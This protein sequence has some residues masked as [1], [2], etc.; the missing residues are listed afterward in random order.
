MAT[1]IRAVTSN[2]GGLYGRTAYFRNRPTRLNWV[3]DKSEAARAVSLPKRLMAQAPPADKTIV[4]SQEH[5]GE[6]LVPEYVSALA[7][8]GLQNHRSGP[9]DRGFPK[10]VQIVRDQAGWFGWKGRIEGFLADRFGAVLIPHVATMPTR[11]ADRL[12]ACRL[13]QR[14]EKRFALWLEGKLDRVLHH[15]KLFGAGLVTATDM[16]VIDTEF[17]QFQAAAEID[18]WA[19]KGILRTRVRLPDGHSVDFFNTH[20]QQDGDVD[21]VRRAQMA[22]MAEFVGSFEGPAVVAGDFNVWEDRPD[23]ASP[24]Y[25]ALLQTMGAVGLRDAF[26]TTH[27]QDPGITHVGRNPADERIGRKVDHLP[28]RRVDYVFVSEEVRVKGVRVLREGFGEDTDHHPL[29]AILEVGRS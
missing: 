24:A 26:R 19:R 7:E 3:F 1:R 9:F 28:D 16:D 21:H 27:P 25:P 20:M 2:S 10:G 23:D 18:H 13:A 6:D 15:E 12:A 8:H 4:L 11:K 14:I 17:H 5:H 22:E 29:E